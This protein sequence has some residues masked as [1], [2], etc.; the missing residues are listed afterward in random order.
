MT[1][2]QKIR[3]NTSGGPGVRHLPLGSVVFCEQRFHRDVDPVEMLLFFYG[4]QGK[5]KKMKKSL[6]LPPI[7]GKST[8]KYK[9]RGG[10]YICIF[11]LT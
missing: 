2:L 6:R 5:C 10:C 8:I 9:W 4:K 1:E 11:T 3:L 7:I